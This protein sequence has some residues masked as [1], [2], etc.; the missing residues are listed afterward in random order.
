[1]KFSEFK[2][3]RPDYEEVKNKYT[4]LLN[5][6]EN[7]N[8]KESFL[9]LFKHIQQL[10]DD[11]NMM[12]TLCFISHSINTKDEFYEKEN[13]SCEELINPYIFYFKKLH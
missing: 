9:D 7:T 11:I 12:S 13:E 4:D 10:D 5:Q 2:Y 1:M 8:D 3:S 6:L